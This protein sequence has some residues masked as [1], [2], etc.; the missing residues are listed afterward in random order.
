MPPPNNRTLMYNKPHNRGT[1]TPN[2]QQ[3]WYV[4]LDMLHYICIISYIPKTALEIVS[5]T[6]ELFPVQKKPTNLSSAYTVTSAPDDL[7]EDL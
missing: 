5:D 2:Y 1:W 4:R 6:T 7:T 3:G